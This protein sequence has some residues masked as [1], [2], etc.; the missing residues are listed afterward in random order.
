M[1]CREFIEFIEQYVAEG[2]SLAE[3][4]AFDAHLAECPD[5]VA[6]L[7]SYRTTIRLSNTAF[8]PSDGPV[9]AE[10]PESLVEAILVARS[11][12]HQQT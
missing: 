6:Y 12:G 3:Q 1:T 8:P 5:C 7:D 9:P 4:E 11:A 10:V 2:L